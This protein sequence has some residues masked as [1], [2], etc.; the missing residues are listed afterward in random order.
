MRSLI[1]AVCLLAAALDLRACPRKIRRRFQR[2]CRRRWVV[3]A[4]SVIGGL[5]AAGA[6]TGQH[7]RV[8]SGSGGIPRLDGAGRTGLTCLDYFSQ[9]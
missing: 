7:L 3:A 9:S 6:G 4:D 8:A 2:S 5:P 1:E